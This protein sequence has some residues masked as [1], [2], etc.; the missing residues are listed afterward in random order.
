MNHS[1]HPS[2]NHTTPRWL[3][4]KSHWIESKKWWTVSHRSFQ[5]MDTTVQLSDRLW[6]F[7]SARLFVGCSNAPATCLCLRMDLY[8]TYPCSHNEINIAD[9]TFYLILT[10]YPDSRPTSPSTNPFTPGACLVVRRVP[11]LKS[12]VCLNQVRQ[13]GVLL[14]LLLCSQ[15]YLWGSPFWVRFLCMWPFFNP[16]IE[17]VTFHLCGWCMLGVFL[18][19][20]FIYL[21]Y[22]CQ[23]LL[24]PCHG[25]HVCTD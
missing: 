24:S 8:E 9:L 13:S 20:A 18:L 16:T 12:L 21:G 19:L 11:M 7:L 5:Q 14:L 15:L 3:I 25:M 17:V 4:H 2:K 1:A 22:E 23:D 10:H 6:R